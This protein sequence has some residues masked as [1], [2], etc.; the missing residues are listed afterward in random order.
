M[1]DIW[2][3]HKLAIL[4][5][6]YIF[7][8]I[9]IANFLAIPFITDIKETSNEIQKKIIDQEIE[10]SKIGQLPKMGE[11]WNNIQLKKDATEVILNKESEVGFIENID[12]LAIRTGNIVDLKIGD[13]TNTKD[14]MKIKASAKNKN[15][16]KG[17]LDEISYLNFF[18]IQISVKGDYNGLVNFVRLL[19]NSR[20]Y[21]N[22][23]SIDSKKQEDDSAS[24]S[25]DVFN[26]SK[27]KEEKEN[28]KKEVIITNINAIVYTKK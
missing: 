16:E 26:A 5:W 12:S 22:I 10:Q 7:I 17:I 2:R 19:E 1:K 13:N 3:K 18:P 27:T 21:V 23:I 11:D 25:S 28:I 15:V 9:G 8:V 4:I 20:F 14:V 24:V 6:G